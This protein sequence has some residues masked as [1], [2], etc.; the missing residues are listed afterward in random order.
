VKNETGA[1]FAALCLLL[2]LP[3]AQVTSC[4]P[5]PAVKDAEMLGADL[6]CAVVSAQP[7]SSGSA[8]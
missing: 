7:T 6:T 4:H 3:F 5:S 1:L 2:L 8:P